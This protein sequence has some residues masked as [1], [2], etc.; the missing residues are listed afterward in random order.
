MCGIEKSSEERLFDNIERRHPPV[1]QRYPFFPVTWHCKREIGESPSD[2]QTILRWKETRLNDQ[3]RKCKNVHKWK[4]CLLC[5]DEDRLNE[6]GSGRNEK[7]A[8]LRSGTKRRSLRNGSDW[9][10]N[11]ENRITTDQ[12]KCQNFGHITSAQL[13]LFLRFVNQMR[14]G[15][16]PISAVMTHS[17]CDQLNI[18]I[19]E[20]K[21]QRSDRPFSTS[22]HPKYNFCHWWWIRCGEG[23]EWTI[24]PN[25]LMTP[26]GATT[27]R[28]ICPM[29]HFDF[30][31]SRQAEI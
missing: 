28:R 20:M 22:H 3:R 23:V 19:P 16:T 17:L 1:R 12:Y 30:G 4:L 13:L 26:L 18:S 21:T 9:E 24:P 6:H 25:D 15:H 10:L 27:G 14:S 31:E 8:D 11:R 29:P 7:N 5:H 2:W